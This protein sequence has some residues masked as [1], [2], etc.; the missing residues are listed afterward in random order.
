MK[1]LKTSVTFIE[2]TF[3]FI[4]IYNYAINTLDYCNKLISIQSQTGQDVLQ[5]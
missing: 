3:S 1:R 4:H 2:Q 5:D